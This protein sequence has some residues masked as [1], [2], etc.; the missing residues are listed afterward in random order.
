MANN[1]GAYTTLRSIRQDLNQLARDPNSI[2]PMVNMQ[3]MT[4]LAKTLFFTAII[5]IPAN[6]ITC[7]NI[8][9]SKQ[10]IDTFYNFARSKL[11]IITLMKGQM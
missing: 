2:S 1:P 10:I 7:I 9:V 4:L 3:H 11:M 5:S 8:A 6:E